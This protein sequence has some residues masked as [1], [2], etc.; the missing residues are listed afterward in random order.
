[1]RRVVLFLVVATALWAGQG[2]VAAQPQAPARDTAPA[3]R[4]GT[5]QIAGRVLAAET[6]LGRCDRWS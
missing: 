2:P 5:S 3:T 6:A 1:M 4:P